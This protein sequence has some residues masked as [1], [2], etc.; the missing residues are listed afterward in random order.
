MVVD[1]RVEVDVDVDDVDDVL[2]E[3]VLDDVDVLELLVEVVEELLVEEDEVVDELVEVD[4]VLSRDSHATLVKASS[5]H[6]HTCFV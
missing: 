1:E 4:V 2:V 6:W 3:V 5:S